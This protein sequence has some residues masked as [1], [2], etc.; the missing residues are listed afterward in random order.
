M[1]IKYIWLMVLLLLWFLVISKAW[2]ADQVDFPAIYI[3]A[4]AGGSGVGSQADPYDTLDDINCTTVGDNSIFDYLAGSPSE[5]PTINLQKG[6]EWNEQMTVGASGTASYPIVIQGYGTGADPIISAAD[7]VTTWSDQGS[8]IYRAEVATTEPLVVLYNGTPLIPADGDFATLTI[9][10]WDWV[11]STTDY[12]Y[13]NV[14]G[15]PGDTTIEAGQRSRPINIDYKSYITI[16]GLSVYGSNKEGIFIYTDEGETADS[17]II[18]NCSVYGNAWSGI[19]NNN[20]GTASNITIRDNTIYTN[21]TAGISIDDG[22]NNWTVSNNTL[23]H[24]GFVSDNSGGIKMVGT[25]DVDDI[26]NI[27][28]DG[29]SISRTGYYTDDTTT[30][31]FGEG[32]GIWVDTIDNTSYTNNVIVRNNTVSNVNKVGIYIEKSHYSEVYYNIINGAKLYGIYMRAG[33]GLFVTDNRF[34]NNVVYG[35]LADGM[36]FEGQ[37]GSANSC[38]DNTAQNNII[39]GSTDAEFYATDGCDNN[40]TEGSGNVYTYNNFGAIYANFITYGASTP[41]DY[42]EWTTAYGSTTYAAEGDPLFVNAGTDFRLI[43]TSSPCYNTGV[44]VNLTEDYDSVNVPQYGG[45]DIGALEY[46]E[47]YIEG[48]S[49]TGVTVQ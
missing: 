4:D 29:N 49:L 13:V 43:S 17:I 24:N 33:L 14:G 40:D 41:D 27:I 48:V 44:D 35:S 37:D 1:S 21:G 3:D 32:T 26:Y 25:A 30:N 11:D 2:G 12:L 23:H 6:D 10:E 20:I 31:S 38:D 45:F 18:Q 5:S 16:D 42:T 19:K 34:Y 46:V 7:L 9:N 36:R 22:S 8:N 28:I 39:D 15:A 47:T